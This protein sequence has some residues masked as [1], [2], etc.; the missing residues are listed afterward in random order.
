[1]AAYVIPQVEVFQDFQISTTAT[2]NP[3][4]AHIS[5]P[6][7]QLVRYNVSSEQPLGV[8][9]YYNNNGQAYTWPNRATGALIDQSYVQLWAQNALLQYYQQDACEAVSTGGNRILSPDNLASGGSAYARGVLPG[10]A[11]KAVFPT[12]AGGGGAMEVSFV[13][14]LAAMAAVRWSRARRGL[15]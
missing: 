3:L 15:L 10:D 5:G 12:P 4:L 6:D 9:G 7:A 13:A 1:M 2:A 14:L 11:V 8:L